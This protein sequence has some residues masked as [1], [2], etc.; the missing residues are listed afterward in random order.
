PEATRAKAIVSMIVA[1]RE[2]P[3]MVLDKKRVEMCRTFQLMTDDQAKHYHENRAHIRKAVL[4]HCDYDLEL[5]HR[6]IHLRALSIVC[7]TRATCD[8]CGAACEMRLDTVHGKIEWVCPTDDSRRDVDVNALIPAAHVL[9]VNVC[10]CGSVAR[11]DVDITD[12][13]YDSCPNQTCSYYH[14]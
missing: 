3:G 2:K 4:T 9:N 1:M 12:N 14:F 8:L 5:F 10:A 7:N 6:Y 11:R 13:F